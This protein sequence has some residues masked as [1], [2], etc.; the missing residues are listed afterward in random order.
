MSDFAVRTDACDLDFLALGAVVHR[1]D[2]G[3]IPFRKARSF[4]GDKDGPVDW[5]TVG[6]ND[7]CPCGSGKKF[8]K[9]CLTSASDSLS[10][11]EPPW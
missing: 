5:A 10:I 1:L 11:G 9:C 7:P 2:P 8:K 3:V 6:R 4:D